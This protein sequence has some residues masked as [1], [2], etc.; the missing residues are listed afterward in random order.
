MFERKNSS[1]VPKQP[2]TMEQIELEDKVAYV[3][4][5]KDRCL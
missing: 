1:E 2:D 3:A 5:L 4:Q